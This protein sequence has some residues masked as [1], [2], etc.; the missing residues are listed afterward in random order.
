[1]RR[2]HLFLC[3]AALVIGAGIAF[4]HVGVEHHWIA[5]PEACTG[6][7]S[8]ITSLEDLKKKLMATQVVRCD[9]LAWTMFGLSVAGYNAIASLILA[10]FSLA[11]AIRRKAL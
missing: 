2:P 11:A 7:P 4:Y 8:G 1:A 9:E 10:A 6:G 5:G 3:A